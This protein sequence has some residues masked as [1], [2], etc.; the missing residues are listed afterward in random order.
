MR[1]FSAPAQYLPGTSPIH[2]L[3]PRC[4]LIC[5]FVFIIAVL[6]AKT[7]LSLTICAL[8]AGIALMLSRIS[9]RNI[10][11]SIAPLLILAIIA[12]LMNLFF[13]QEG[14]ILFQLGFIKISEQGYLT[15]CFIGSRLLIMVMGMGIITLT[16]PNL[17][18]TEAFERIGKP[19]RFLHVPV[20]ELAMMMSLALKFIPQFSEELFVV[21]MAQISRG[22]SFSKGG[23]LQR[24]KA[25]SALI[26][27]L[28]SSALRHAETLSFA[29]EARCYH[30]EE[31]RTRLHQL[32]YN[33]CDAIA[34]FF[35]FTFF[36]GI[37]LLNYL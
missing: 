35:T 23:I 21:Y 15:A 24:L 25:V 29:M 7:P 30:G 26:I 2:L 10:C 12:A 5:G 34:Y 14:P 27:P 19:L 3:D 8:F 17:D 33:T 20:H 1:K 32:K 13:V 18:I 28:F 31:G 11:R 22:A 6:M 9:L 4:K 36:A 16:T 37:L